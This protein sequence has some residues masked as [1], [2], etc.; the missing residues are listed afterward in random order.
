L[1]IIFL[2]SKRKNEFSSISKFF[3]KPGTVFILIIPLAITEW[4]V[5]FYGFGGRIYGGWGILTFLVLFLFGYY[6]FS[7][8]SV[9]EAVEKQRFYALGIFIVSYGIWGFFLFSGM[10]LTSISLNYFIYH[11][12]RALCMLSIL[13]TI[14]GF[15]NRKLKFTNRFLSYS[16]E[17]ALPFYI[18][19]QPVILAIG[20]FISS[21][22]W[23]PWL[24]WLFLITMSL[25]GIMLVYNLIVRPFNPIRFLFGMKLKKS[26]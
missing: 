24:K 20:F 10:D 9:R 23:Q 11:L 3:S 15:T 17:A 25:I 12:V 2:I 7:S 8:A 5:P 6:I 26:K 22:E 21:W 1:L 4:I 19:H 14:I 16:N 18:L 13:L